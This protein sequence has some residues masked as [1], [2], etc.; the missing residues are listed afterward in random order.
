M[1]LPKWEDWEDPWARM[2]RLR[3]AMTRSTHACCWAAGDESEPLWRLY[4]TN[5]G[6]GVGVALRTTLAKLEASVAHDLYVS[7]I[8]YRH[9]HEGPAFD[10][11]L[12]SFMHKRNGFWAE[13][14]VRLLKFDRAHFHALISAPPTAAELEEHL[15]LDWP[16]ADAIEK[17]VLSP[18]AATSTRCHRSC[19][20]VTARPRNPVGS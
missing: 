13:K 1:A 19:G 10:D 14:E 20:R 18:Y 16:A 6:P 5:D 12:D 2:T 17:I 11:E 15:F 7:L 8:R 4:C 9:Y 3:R